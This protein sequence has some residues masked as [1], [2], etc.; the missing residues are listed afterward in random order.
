MRPGSICIIRL[1]GL[2]C[3]DR[4]CEPAHRNREADHVGTPGP[5]TRINEEWLQNRHL[6]RVA[7]A[8]VRAGFEPWRLETTTPKTPLGTEPRMGDLRSDI[9]QCN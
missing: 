5:H 1:G 3:C 9:A 4:A 2:P 7:G 8:V 6:L